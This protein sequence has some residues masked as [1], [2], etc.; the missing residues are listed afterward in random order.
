MRRGEL[1]GPKVGALT[2]AAIADPTR[3]G[4]LLAG[5]APEPLARVRDRGVKAR[6]DAAGADPAATI[7][8]IH[9]GR[10]F[11]P[12][13][14]AEGAS[15]DQGRDTADRGARLLAHLG[16]MATEGQRDWHRRQE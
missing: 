12:W 8:A 14:D 6:A 9:A 15:C 5:A 11:S 16:P 7:R 2:G 4:D 1:S 3:E 10:R 13:T